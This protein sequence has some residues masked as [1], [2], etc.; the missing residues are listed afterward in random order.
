MI[1]LSDEKL[2][3][4][5]DTT[6]YLNQSP[7]E[8]ARDYYDAQIDK[9]AK[10]MEELISI[11]NKFLQVP[12]YDLKRAEKFAY[13]IGLS[14]SDTSFADSAY[15]QAFGYFAGFLAAGGTIKE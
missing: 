15:D 11:V 1:K 7:C 12:F 8:A 14:Y 4:I 13:D 5:I 6:Y 10:T 2:K 3:E 9:Q